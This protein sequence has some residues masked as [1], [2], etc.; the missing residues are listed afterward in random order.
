MLQ[1]ENAVL[2]VIDVQGKLATLMHK[3]KRL[4][5]NVNRMIAGAKAFNIPI[6]WTEQLPDKLGETVAEIRQNLAGVDLLTKSCFSCAGG[7]GFN[8]KLAE[9]GRKQVLVCGI[10][11]HICVYQTCLDL[12]KN[13]YEVHLV[14]DG[15]SSRFKSN[16]YLA[17][18]KLKG[19]G[20]QLTSVEMSL[21][22]M[23]VVA[24]GDDFKKLVQI[25][26]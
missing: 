25:V 6:I 22:E 1:K 17:L 2:V 11:A 8:E 16:Y 24:E 19:A 20:A 7:P 21:F 4:F 23:Q 3:H 12:L 9:T 10:E 13:D 18:D 14:I 26:K 15:V 5:E